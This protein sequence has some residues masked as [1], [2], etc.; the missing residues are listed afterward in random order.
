MKNGKWGFIDKNGNEVLPFRYEHTVMRPSFKKG[1][2]RV[3]LNG[4]EFYI[5]KKGNEVR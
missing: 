1:V 4:R 5:D 3:K 2:A